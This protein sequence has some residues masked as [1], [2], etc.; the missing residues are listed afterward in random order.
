MNEKLHIST[1]G[2]EMTQS[3]IRKLAHLAYQAEDEGVKIY[4][5]NI[6]SQ[7]CR[8]LRRLLMP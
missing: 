6:A 3:P 1:C 7:T 4:R 2:W 8:L 5:L